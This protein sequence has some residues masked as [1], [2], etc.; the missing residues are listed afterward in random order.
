M[1]ELRE[2]FEMT[3]KQVEP[4]VEAWREQEG[5]QHRQS[6]RRRIGTYVVVA[7]MFVVASLFVVRILDRSHEGTTPGGGGQG[8]TTGQ[9]TTFSTQLP[10]AVPSG[11]LAAETYRTGSFD[12]VVTFTVGE[13]WWVGWDYGDGIDLAGGA[14]SI[15]KELGTGFVRISFWDTTTVPFF[16]D[17]EAG[18][19][20]QDF[21]AYLSQPPSGVKDLEIRD[22]A[23][24][25]L[26]A[27]RLDFEVVSPLPDITIGLPDVPTSAAGFVWNDLDSQHWIVV[28]TPDGQLL[29]NWTIEEATED[30]ESLATAERYFGEVMQTVQLAERP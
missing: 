30:A 22:T 28:D 2:V 19:A 12:P 17:G 1:P 23:V 14:L 6:M 8:S 24:D 18:P 9:S 20:P 25:G 11:S 13:G 27:T 29:F 10:R 3:T 21:A 16:Y 7:A 26:S 5:R 15:E 4:D